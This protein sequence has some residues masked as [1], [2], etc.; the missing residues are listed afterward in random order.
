MS[1][2]Q[3]HSGRRT[4]TSRRFDAVTSVARDHCG[5]LVFV[6]YLIVAIVIERNA[7]AHIATVCACNGGSA[8][9]ARFSVPT[10]FMWALKWWPHAIAHLQNPL[11]S[12]DVWTPQGLNLA[13]A[14]SVRPQPWSRVR[15]PLFSVRWSRSTF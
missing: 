8:Y 1:L 14:T 9:P 6:L 11:I 15:S 4:L 3:A 10:A 7:V 13:R 5:A 2:S 12:H